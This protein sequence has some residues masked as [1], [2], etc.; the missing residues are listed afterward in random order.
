MTNKDLRN[1][2]EMV[3]P[4]IAIYSYMHGC[5]VLSYKDG[6]ADLRIP[7]SVGLLILLSFD[8][9]NYQLQLT[10]II[11]L[12]TYQLKSRFRSCILTEF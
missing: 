2:D 4:Y 1:L 8:Q 3:Y 5:M 7:V 11:R 12:T 10:L 6:G 9:S